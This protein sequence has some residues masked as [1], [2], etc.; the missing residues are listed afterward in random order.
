MTHISPYVQMA[1]ENLIGTY[2]GRKTMVIFNFSFILYVS[3]D[4]SRNFNIY[5]AKQN[6][7]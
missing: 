6:Y 1:I 5:L 4:F 7:G 3:K 2:M